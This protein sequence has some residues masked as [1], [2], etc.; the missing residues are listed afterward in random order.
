[1]G[2]SLSLGL[3][4]IVIALGGCGV[5]STV[6]GGAQGISRR[7]FEGSEA[8]RARHVAEDDSK[9]R[10]LGFKP[11]TEAYGNCRLQAEQIR[12]TNAAAASANRSVTCRPD[13]AGGVRCR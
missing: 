1:M 2:R 10:E 6:S 13:Y 5:A 11:G 4:L 9:C 7:I 8:R 3:A 12:A